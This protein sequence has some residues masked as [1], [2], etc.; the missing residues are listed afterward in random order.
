[1]EDNMADFPDDTLDKVWKRQNGLCAACG[2]ELTR[3]NRKMGQKGAW[4]PHHRV[5]EDGGGSV[6]LRNCVIFCI[7]PEGGCHLK[8]GHSGDWTKHPTLD[9]KRLPYLDIGKPKPR[10]KH[11]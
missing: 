10:K 1:M 4:H 11:R 7:N 2:K 8:I 6:S 5:R 9:N 3:K